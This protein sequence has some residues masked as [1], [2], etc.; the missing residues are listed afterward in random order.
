MELERVGVLDPRT[1]HADVIAVEQDLGQFGLRAGVVAASR[2]AELVWMG[3]CSS[4]TETG[5]LIE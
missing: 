1:H 2:L 3:F 4:E 5:W